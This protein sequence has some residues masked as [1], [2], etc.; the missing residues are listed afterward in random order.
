MPVLQPENAIQM[1]ARAEKRPYMI[2]NTGSWFGSSV[3]STA[4]MFVCAVFLFL[5]G[6]TGVATLNL[7]CFGVTNAVAVGLWINRRNLN[8]FQALLV[9][10]ATLSFAIPIA[11]LATSQ[12]AS[13]AV[14]KSMNWP[15]SSVVTA[16]VLFAAPATTLWFLWRESQSRPLSP[17]EHA[18]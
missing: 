2:W 4:W 9:L 10:L 8:A 14:L 16:C 6:Q 18:G 17:Q 1:N 15:T 11:W 7:A 5:H 12:L 13:D 3:G